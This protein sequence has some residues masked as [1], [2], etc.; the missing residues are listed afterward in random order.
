MDNHQQVGIGFISAGLFALAGTLCLL[1][2]KAYLPRPGGRRLQMVVLTSDD[3]RFW[4]AVA[5]EFGLALAL[6]GW[7]G[8]A[9]IDRFERFAR[10]VTAVGLIGVAIGILAIFANLIVWW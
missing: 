10:P 9:N 7:F 6:F 1:L 3:W 4:A 5:G 8:L 2:G